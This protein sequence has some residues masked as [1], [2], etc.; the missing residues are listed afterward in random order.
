MLGE[1]R[2]SILFFFCLKGSITF[3]GEINDANEDEDENDDDH[4]GKVFDGCRGKAEMKLW[5][6]D[7]MSVI[8]GQG[9]IPALDEILIRDKGIGL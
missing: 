5:M 8:A 1:Y 4:P 9:L 7:G 2:N 6:N 3:G